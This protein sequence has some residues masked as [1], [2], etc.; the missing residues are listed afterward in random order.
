M[1]SAHCRVR[2]A[3]NVVQVQ[4]RAAVSHIVQVRVLILQIPTDRR[5]AFGFVLPT[6]FYDAV[7]LQKSESYLARDESP[8]VLFP[9]KCA[10]QSTRHSVYRT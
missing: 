5:L 6:A 7:V 9:V 8:S 3:K 4:R 10:K 1:T 2:C